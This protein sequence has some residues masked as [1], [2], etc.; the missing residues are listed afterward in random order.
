MIN[1]D[2]KKIWEKQ[3][4]I[5]KTIKKNSS[6]I[7]I[8]WKTNAPN[9]KGRLYSLNCGRFQMDV[10]FVVYENRIALKDS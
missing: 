1:R 5:R 2:M 4:R 6:S 10:I 3:I 8:S 9:L 7:Y